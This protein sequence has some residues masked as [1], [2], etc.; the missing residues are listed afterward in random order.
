MPRIIS[1]TQAKNHFGS[2]V[3]WVIQQNEQVVVESHGEPRIVIIPFGD[4]DEFV[5][6]KEQVRREKALVML[7]RLGETVR[8]RNYDLTPEEGDFLAGRFSEELVQEIV[9][10][11]RIRFE[12]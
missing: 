10:E 7:R 8:A 4:Y 12:A 9:Q 6:L 11:G 5:Q 3:Q 2:I 1:A